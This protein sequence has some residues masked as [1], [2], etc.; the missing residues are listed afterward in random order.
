ME[1]LKRTDWATFPLGP[2]AFSDSNM[3]TVIASRIYWI[4]IV[5]VPLVDAFSSRRLL[6]FEFEFRT[7]NSQPK[8][9]TH[10][11]REHW[12]HETWHTVFGGLNSRA[13]R[14]SPIGSLKS[15]TKNLD[16]QIFSP[17]PPPPP[18]LATRLSAYLCVKIAPSIRRYSLR[19]AIKVVAVK[20][21]RA[22][23]DYTMFH[24][25]SRYSL[26]NRW[27]IVLANRL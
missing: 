12:L 19:W 9:K 17:V 13:Y 2:L 6:W 11:E 5:G 26:L 7:S 20:V 23:H 21:I 18:L 1:T 10:E 16:W 4:P 22:R 24:I 14:T 25:G 27:I 8:R 3:C 15:T